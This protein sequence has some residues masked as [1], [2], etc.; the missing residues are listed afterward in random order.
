V[1]DDPAQPP[2]VETTQGALRGAWDGGVATFR[3]IPYAAPPIG[4]L[5]FRPPEPFANWRGTRDATEFGP[6]APQAPSRLSRVMG[7]FDLPQ[8]EDCLTLNIWASALAGPPAPVLFWLHGGAFTS[9]AGSLPW[10]WGREFARNGR[11]VV[12]TVTYRLGPLGFLYLPGICD[13]NLGLMDQ[14]AALRW[15]KANIARFGGDADA[16][17]VAGQSAGARST[18]HLMADDATARLFRRAIVQSGPLDMPPLSPDEAA[19]TGR[20]YVDLLGVP[21][22]DLKDLPAAKLIE[23]AGQLAQRTKRFADSRAPF[24]AVDD[25][26]VVRGDP[27]AAIER[28]AGDG[29]EVLI[30]TTRDESAAHLV[31]DAEIHDADETKLRQRFETAFGKDAEQYLAEIRRL[32]PTGT[33]Y[34]ALVQL[35]TDTTFLRGSVA[36]A[37]ARARQGRPAYLYRFDWQSPMRLLGACHCIELPFVF[38]NFADWTDAPMLAGADPAETAALAKAMHRAWIAFIKTGDPNHDGMP[39]WAPYDNRGRVTMRFDDVVEP[40][41]DLAGVGWRRSLGAGSR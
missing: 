7:D 8:S 5:R 32:R 30:G 36:F 13:G 15:V 19:E 34:A 11:I 20:R 25:G 4:D 17:T 31:F 3:G 41:G 39:G 10:Y 33:S 26:A 37:E 38:D 23:A 24:N 35:V 16:I 14:I 40:V 27:L 9:G 12:V 6:I 21:A 22:S 2:L 28:G 1:R 29:I 18:A